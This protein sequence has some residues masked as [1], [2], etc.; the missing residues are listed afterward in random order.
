MVP[1]AGMRQ[2]WT[3]APAELNPGRDGGPVAFRSPEV[4]PSLALTTTLAALVLAL[5]GAGAALAQTAA[6]QQVFISPMGEPFRAPAGQPYPSALWFAGADAN[7]D[8]ALSRAEFRADA[9]RFFKVL[10]VNGDG[11]LT[12]IEVDIYE[13][14]IA[15]EIVV[16]SSDTS[17]DSLKSNDNGDGPSRNTTLSPIKQG[18]ANYS[19]RNDPEPVRSADTD[20]NMKITQDE[21]MAAADRRFA[22]LLPDGKDVVT[23][24]DLPPTP[25]QGNRPRRK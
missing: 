7:H 22:A 24:A 12:N 15:P 17:A 1:I 25:A 14:R 16:A 8:E 2:P 5:P 10:D 23:F 18:A 21:F 6:A 9:L 19:W 11:K 13:Y 4:R 3:A 20:F